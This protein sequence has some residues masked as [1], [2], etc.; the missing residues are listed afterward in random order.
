MGITHG[1]ES[2]LLVAVN[3]ETREMVITTNEDRLT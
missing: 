3:G 1:A 2:R